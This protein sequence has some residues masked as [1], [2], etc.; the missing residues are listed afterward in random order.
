[1]AEEPKKPVPDRPAGEATDVQPAFDEASASL[2]DALRTSF[3]VLTFIIVGLLVV[4]LLQGL[5]TVQSDQKAII[6][7]FGAYEEGRVKD[8]GIHYALP[9]PIDRVVPI[10]VRTRELGVN[11]FWNMVS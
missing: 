1:V 8:Q 6:L 4:F 3:S 11:T 10:W 2:A 5:F 7:R 9:Y